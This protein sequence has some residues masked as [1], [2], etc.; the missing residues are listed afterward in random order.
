MRICGLFI[1]QFAIVVCPA[2]VSMD[3]WTVDGLALRL[4]RLARLRKRHIGNVQCEFAPLCPF[5]QCDGLRHLVMSRSRIVVEPVR[6]N[7]HVMHVLFQEL[8]RVCRPYF[9]TSDCWQ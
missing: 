7:E 1:I 3:S 2:N 9:T 6:L 4:D 5:K 8:T